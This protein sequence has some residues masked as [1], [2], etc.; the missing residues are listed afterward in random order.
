MITCDNW[1]RKA[2]RLENL[3]TVHIVRKIDQLPRHFDHP[4]YLSIDKDVLSDRF[5]KLGWDQGTMALDELFEAVEFL[6]ENF[7]MVGV[8][9]SGEPRDPFEMKQS[10]QINLKLLDIVLRHAKQPSGRSLFRLSS[11]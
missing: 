2:K 3:E 10:E 11:C 6:C 7:E 5:L 4:I 1:I 8:D 9:I